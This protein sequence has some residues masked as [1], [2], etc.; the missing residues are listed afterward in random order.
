MRTAR[1]SSRRGG[2]HQPPPDQAPQEQAPHS[3]PD[4]PVDRHTPVNILPC[5]KLRLRAVII[6][7]CRWREKDRYVWTDPHT[8]RYRTR[9][10]F[11][12][13][14]NI[15]SQTVPL[16]TR[17]LKCLLPYSVMVY[18]HPVALIT[19]NDRPSAV[20][21]STPTRI[22]IAILFRHLNNAWHNTARLIIGKPFYVDN[23]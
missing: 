23:C 11:K 9:N 7:E 4:P 18:S 19:S 21:S 13:L 8:K 6:S 20:Q 14:V 22:H 10:A 3:G 17:S 1:S 16:E 5:P 12:T 2:L 15:F